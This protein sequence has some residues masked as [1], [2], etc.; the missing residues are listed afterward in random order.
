MTAEII[1][2]FRKAIENNDKKQLALLLEEIHPVDQSQLLLELEQD[3]RAKIYN[4]LETETLADIIQELDPD[5]QLVLLEELQPRQIPEVLNEMSSDDAADL[6][7]SLQDDHA[8][9]LLNSM[10]IEDAAEVRRLLTFPEETAGGLMTTEFVAIRRNLTASETLSE[11]RKIAP[12]AETIYYIYVTD[13]KNRLA[14]VISLR[15]LIVAPPEQMIEAIMSENVVSVSVTM[16]QEDVASV[17]DKYDFLAVP[18]VDENNVLLG[19]V[20]VDDVLDV[21]KE[22]ATQDIGHLSA[23]PHMD[24]IKVTAL[25]SAKRRLPWLIL[26]L[27]V[28]LM[29]GSIIS[30]FETTLEQVI[31]LAAFIPLI[32]D[33]AGNTGTQSLAI[34]VRGLA[35]GEFT[36][37]DVVQIIK[38]EFATGLIIG[39]TCGVIIAVA[40]FIWQ[41]NPYL[42][43]V[44]GFSLWATLISATLAGAIVPIFINY[45]NLDPAVA[46]GPF[47]T[48]I[49]DIIGLTIFFTTAT[50]F[51][52][53]LI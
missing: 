5:E 25:Q 28:D 43:V 51:M 32:A 19:I 7:G 50:A 6:L 24:E 12:N 38:R 53:Y 17:I 52:S 10:S 31:I 37:K 44:V 46:S 34:V 23:I 27:F 11:L 9:N 20:T 30:R 42:G 35:L 40:A 39:T 8:Q 18:V 48:T 26:L 1:N 15:D 29:S 13:D 47:I 36:K 49:N 21:L 22:E 3:E 41:G 16:D 45:L 2:I 14:G 4:F 33:M